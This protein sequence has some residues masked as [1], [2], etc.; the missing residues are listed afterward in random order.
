MSFLIVA[1]AA[2]A[3]NRSVQAWL[4]CGYAAGGTSRL[5]DVSQHPTDGRAALTIPTS[6]G[7][8]QIGLAQEAYD[9]LLSGAERAALLPALPPDWQGEP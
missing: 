6:P 2:A 1:T 3:H 4:D 8:A 7:D 5:W 9:A